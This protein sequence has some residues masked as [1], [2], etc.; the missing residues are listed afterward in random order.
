MSDKQK[1]KEY[2][3]KQLVQIQKYIYR[4]A[5]MI[6]VEGISE[7]LSGEVLKIASLSDD[8]IT[9]KYPRIGDLL[10]ELLFA[11]I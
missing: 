5:T 8:E 4:W 1:K 9:S 2:S 11:K 7:R 10:I 3:Q 6:Y